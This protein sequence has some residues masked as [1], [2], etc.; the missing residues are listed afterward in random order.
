MDSAEKKWL[1]L[2][3]KCAVF[4]SKMV[5]RMDSIPKVFEKA[6][7]VS[8]ERDAKNAVRMEE[9]SAAQHRLEMLK[10][11]AEMTR[12]QQTL[13]IEKLQHELSTMR[14]ASA[15]DEHNKPF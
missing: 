15:K 5:D 8:A 10:L 14:F 7:D 6:I 1:E 13:E 3:E 9:I 2:V 11:E 12:L 4:C